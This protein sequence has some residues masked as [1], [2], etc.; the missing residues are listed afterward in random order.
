MENACPFLF[1]IFLQIKRK[2]KWRNTVYIRK[3]LSESYKNIK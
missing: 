1:L 3:Y 2:K